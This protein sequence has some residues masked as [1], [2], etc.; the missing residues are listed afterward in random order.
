[1]NKSIRCLLTFAGLAAACAANAAP[2][3]LYNFSFVFADANG[4]HVDGSFA[5]SDFDGSG[6]LHDMQDVG[7]TFF[8]WNG[9]GLVPIAFSGPLVF[10]HYAWNGWLPGEGEVSA[11]PTKNNFLISDCT[12]F[13]ATGF[14]TGGFTN[15]VMFRQV[16][17]SFLGD[18][19]FRAYRPG[20]TN[21]DVSDRGPTLEGTWTLTQVG[22]VGQV[23]EPEA[24]AMLLAGLGLLGFAARRR[25]LKEAAAA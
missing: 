11:D 16:D 9:A 4:R 13:D 22:V 18:E 24:Y 10:S 14:C 15:T 20:G 23:P 25:K 19:I 12:A 2:T 21:I 8:E 1:V 17:V 6:H 7:A 5:A 3:H